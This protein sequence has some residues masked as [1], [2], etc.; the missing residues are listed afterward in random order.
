MMR[1]VAFRTRCTA[2]VAASSA[3]LALSG[4][5]RQHAPVA[6]GSVATAQR[7]AHP[8]PAV[9]ALIA[10]CRAQDEPALMRIFGVDAASLV[11]TGD[12]ERDR[13]RCTLLVE[14]AGQMTRL[15]PKGP[16]ML[17]LVV[18]L[19]DFPFPVPLVWDGSG[20]RF[21]IE[22]GAQEIARRRVGA[23]ELDAI[24]V[25]R[26]F[27]R[28]RQVPG[29]EWHGYGFRTAPGGDAVVAY[30]AAYGVTGIMTFVGAGGRV[31]EKDLGT[32]TLRTI[33][34]MRTYQPDGTW[35]A[36]E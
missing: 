31:Y 2:L 8:Q 22:E 23:S 25:C 28:T 24:A 4:C 12:P 19:D 18:G 5:A 11:S 15:D 30:P 13:H 33:E 20:W 1:V 21:D 3:L 17:E 9:D 7:F 34:G 14:A 29:A 32:K 26:A 27:A 10:A 6:S 35:T 16:N 36:V